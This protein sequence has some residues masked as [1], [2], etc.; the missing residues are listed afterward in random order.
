MW[1]CF[2]CCTSWHILCFKTAKKN[3]YLMISTGQEPRVSYLNFLLRNSPCWSQ[4]YMRAVIFP[5]APG[6]LLHSCF[7]RVAF[8]AVEW[9]KSPFP[10]RLLARDYSGFAL[11]FLPGGPLYS[12]L[13]IAAYFFTVMGESSV[14]CNM[15]MGVIPMLLPYNLNL[16]RKHPSHS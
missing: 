16:S 11:R 14:C 10:Y 9:L 6:P 3:Y 13:S 1:I 5:K 4:G 8:F 15:I 12:P 7:G 2:Y